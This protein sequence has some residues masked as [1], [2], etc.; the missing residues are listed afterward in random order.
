MNY[1][2]RKN[3]A[4]LH[5]RAAVLEELGV[6]LLVAAHTHVPGVVLSVG[7]REDDRQ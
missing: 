6:V 1:T 4:N 7:L 3:Q 2:G 5:R